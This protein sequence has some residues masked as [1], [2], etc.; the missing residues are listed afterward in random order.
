MMIIY[1]VNL[2]VAP[3]VVPLCFDELIDL[4]RLLC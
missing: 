4:L 3:A 2:L 1:L